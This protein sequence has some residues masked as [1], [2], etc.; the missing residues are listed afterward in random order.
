MLFRV[1]FKSL[2]DR[3]TSVGLCLF[4][5]GLSVFLLLATEQLRQQTRASFYSSVSGIDLIVGPRTGQLNLLLY[6]VFHLGA[7]TNNISWQSYK[8]IA[9]DSKV[10]WSI[11]LSLGDSHRG[12]RVLGTEDAFFQHYRY[13]TKQPLAFA[14]GASFN[15]AKTVVLGAH[16]AK[17]LGYKLGQ[18]ITIAHGLK[19][20]RFN[21]HGDHPLTI[22]GILRPTGTPI[23]R[24]VIVPLEALEAVHPQ[25]KSTNPPERQ[26]ITALMLG[27]KSKMH[28]FGLQRYINQY[29]EEALMAILPGV[30]LTEL[31]QITAIVEASIN[32]IAIL[33]LLSACLGMSAMI[34]SSLRER[35]QEMT[36]LRRLGA[37]PWYI[38]GLIQ[39]EA[40]LICTSACAI[41]ALSIY[42]LL[43]LLSQLLLEHFQIMLQPNLLTKESGIM[44]LV[45]LACNQLLACLPA[46]SAYRRSIL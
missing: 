39:A 7:P 34:I 27:L 23:D 25:P 21:Q 40:F 19:A 6:S 46:F 3:K 42:A 9:Q 31:W 5:I 36:I 22:S 30:A 17:Q 14:K 35:Q 37:S 43:P 24:L 38:F 2:L 13:G 8:N 11:P 12:F 20:T 4:T 44:V 15:H 32:A 28:S 16:V 45:V 10:A 18:K 33:V 29:P 1:A 41:A 26:S